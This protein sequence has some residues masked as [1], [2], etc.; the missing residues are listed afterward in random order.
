M[1][2]LLQNTYT[3]RDSTLCELLKCMVCTCSTRYTSHLCSV[4]SE[5][6]I[7]E[8]LRSDSWDAF[9]SYSLCCQ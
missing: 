4:E 2:W 9:S 6:V 1:T 8:S 5:N 7:S 3:T